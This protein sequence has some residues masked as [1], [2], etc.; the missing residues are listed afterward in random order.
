MWKCYPHRGEQSANF[1]IVPMLAFNLNV[2][3][4]G[5]N[6]AL[7]KLPCEHIQIYFLMALAG[8]AQGVK[9]S[10][11]VYDMAAEFA[12]CWDM[13]GTTQLKDRC[14]SSPWFPPLIHPFPNWIPL[15]PLGLSRALPGWTG[16]T[17]FHDRISSFLQLFCSSLLSS[18]ASFV[19]PLVDFLFH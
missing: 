16:S 8:L 3:F 1:S 13:W 17:L 12:F 7:L 11:F 6:V 2:P 9:T 4:N 5:P 19:F 15:T 10:F 14:G 18:F